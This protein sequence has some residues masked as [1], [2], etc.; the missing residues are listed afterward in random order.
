MSLNSSQTPELYNC[1]L[2]S[3]SCSDRPKL[4][5]LQYMIQQ[6]EAVHLGWGQAPSLDKKMTYESTL[7]VPLH[8]YR[9]Y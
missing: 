6:V 9:E 2:H 5:R 4:G 7:W 1:S 8:E 3:C